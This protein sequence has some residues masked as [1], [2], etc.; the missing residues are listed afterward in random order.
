MAKNMIKDLSDL[1]SLFPTPAGTESGEQER[2]VSTSN[3]GAA[4]KTSA[5]AKAMAM[6]KLHVQLEKKGRKGKGVTVVK[7]FF[8]TRKD[9]EDFARTLKTRCGSGGTVKDDTIEIQGDHR[10]VIIDFFRALG[11]KV[12]GGG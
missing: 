1:H 11:F 7:G 2:A 8:H 3:T 9:L 4:A 10:T 6:S 12:T 5:A